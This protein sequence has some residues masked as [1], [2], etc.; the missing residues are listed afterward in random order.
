[1]S[2]TQKA[3]GFKKWI[4]SYNI[5]V[6]ILG[7]FKGTPYYA[8]RKARF[9]VPTYGLTEGSNF[10]DAGQY[11]EAASLFNLWHRQPAVCEILR[12]LRPTAQYCL[13]S[14]DC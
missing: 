14:Q 8:E 7:A 1:M 10:L 2:N 4:N 9:P 12:L 11:F 13:D 3:E 6:D 5:Y